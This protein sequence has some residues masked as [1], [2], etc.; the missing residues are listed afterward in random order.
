MSG[1]CSVTRVV[2]R[3]PLPT[4]SSSLTTPS[5]LQ[6]YPYIA[7][8]VKKSRNRELAEVFESGEHAEGGERACGARHTVLLRVALRRLP[9]WARMR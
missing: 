6:A 4:A 7:K 2:S 3:L 5:P 9:G 1:C 8:D